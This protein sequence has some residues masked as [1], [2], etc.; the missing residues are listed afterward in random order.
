MS[1]LSIRAYRKI[2]LEVMMSEEY[3]EVLRSILEVQK[4]TLRVQEDLLET[5]TLLN[6]LILTMRDDLPCVHTYSSN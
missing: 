5:L 6:G 2:L 3:H 1:A 4:K